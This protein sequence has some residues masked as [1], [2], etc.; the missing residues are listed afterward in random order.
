MD[1]M[2]RLRRAT[3]ARAHEKFFADGYGW[4]GREDTDAA[5]EEARA[6]ERELQ[7]VLREFS[8]NGRLEDKHHGNYMTTPHFA[9]WY[10]TDLDRA[11][12][13]ER[14]HLRRKMLATLLDA[15]EGGFAGFHFNADEEGWTE[16]SQGE[17]VAAGRTL[18]VLGLV[19]VRGES[20]GYIMLRLTSEGVRVTTDPNELA[21][22][23]PVSGT[24]DDEGA[25]Q[26]VAD[27]MRTLI[28]D[29]EQLLEAR[30]WSEALAE[31][32]EGDDAFAYERWRDAVREYYRAAESGLKY[33]L[34]EADATFADSTALRKL[35]ALAVQ[36][37][38]IPPNYQDMFGFLDSIR[39]PRSHGG[40]PKPKPVP[41]GRNEALLMGNHAR[42][43]LLYLGGQC[44]L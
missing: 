11:A 23:L 18:E 33:R 44:H 42:A 16:H 17:L 12:F 28:F 31:L 40:G 10:E 5:R 43:L 14:N 27:A 38:L 22:T 37:D 2:D 26:I 6:S 29:V 8:E 34:A 30:G 7:L 21:K 39:S 1:A 15:D 32:K 20:S 9:L 4:I 13:Y 36:H 24:E 35:A 3:A 25:E 41:V 19:D